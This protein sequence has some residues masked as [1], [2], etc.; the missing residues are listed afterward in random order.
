MEEDVKKKGRQCF[1]SRSFIPL[2][3]KVRH[4]RKKGQRRQRIGIK[5]EGNEKKE[6]R[7]LMRKEYVLL[8][9]GLPRC[10]L[11]TS[12]IQADERGKF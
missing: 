8:P 3:G 11:P 12:A 10:R 2:P 1:P 9:S 5:K 4:I 7:S 6:I